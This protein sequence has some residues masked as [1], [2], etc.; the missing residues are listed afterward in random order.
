M[1]RI[2]VTILMAAMLCALALGALADAEWICSSCGQANTTNFCGNCGTAAPSWTCTTCQTVNRGNFCGNCGASKESSEPIY[3]L[4][5][6]FLIRPKAAEGVFVFSNTTDSTVYFKDYSKEDIIYPSVL[7]TNNSDEEK[8]FTLKADINGAGFTWNQPTTLAPGETA[9][10][11]LPT[12]RCETPMIYN[13]QC[14]LNDKV[15]AT[16]AYDV[17][18]EESGRIQ[19]IKE[20]AEMPATLRIFNRAN[21]ELVVD[22]IAFG[23]PGML[24]SEDEVFAIRITPYIDPELAEYVLYGDETCE[25]GI[26]INDIV[27]LGWNKTTF[28]ELFDNSGYQVQITGNLEEQLVEGKNVCHFYVDGCRIATYTFDFSFGSGTP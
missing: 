18:D 15:E 10:R 1:K 14:I 27:C 22:H 12:A 17:L 7:I 23:T 9:R 4:E 16:V 19:F 2:F 13:V 5:P 3:S 21:N 24:R 20:F 25:L 26:S 6:C 8:T 11:S 28:A